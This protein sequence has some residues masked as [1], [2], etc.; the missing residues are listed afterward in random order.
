M[1]FLSERQRM[2]IAIWLRDRASGLAEWICPELNPSKV[3]SQSSN[4]SLLFVFAVSAALIAAFVILDASA[5]SPFT[6]PETMKAGAH[7]W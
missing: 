1:R 4:K 3:P 2:T 5:S 7:A 6:R